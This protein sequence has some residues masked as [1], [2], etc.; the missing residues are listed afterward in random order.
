MTLTPSF[1]L[2]LLEELLRLL[3]VPDDLLLDFL[4]L[5]LAGPFLRSPMSFFIS[6]SFTRGSF[7]LTAS[8]SPSMTFSRLA[9]TPSVFRLWPTW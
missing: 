1:R 6:S 2:V 4:E 8:C 5:G 7:R 3:R 9:S